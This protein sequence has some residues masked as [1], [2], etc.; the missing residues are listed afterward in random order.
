MSV[1]LKSY[2]RDQ[3]RRNAERFSRPI[4]IARGFGEYQE[5]RRAAEAITPSACYD[6]ATLQAEGYLR[7]EPPSALVSEVVGSSRQKLAE[8]RTLPQSRN[9]AFFSQLLAASDLGLDGPFMRFALD[10]K[11]LAT[12]ARYLGVAPFLESVELLYSKPID[13]QPAQSQQWHRDRTDRRIIKVFVYAVD[14]TARQGP[15]SLLSRSDSARVP[16]L[17]FHYV[18]DDQMARYVDPGRTVALTGPA[19]TTVMTD[20]QA[21]YHLG[22]RC[23]EPRLAYIAYYSSGFGYRRRE[24]TWQVPESARASLSP[25]QGFALGSL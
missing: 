9:K 21:C 17:L 22:S 16:E 19:G 12:T 2:V 18:P 23:Q 3:V 4:R 20:T 1:S 25:L 14:V 13:G 15:L 7:I 11:L 6:V 5:R 10:E 24:A 8:V